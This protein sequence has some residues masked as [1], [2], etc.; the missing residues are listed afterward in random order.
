M[1]IVT[2]HIPY[3]I[4]FSTLAKALPTLI[5]LCITIGI[6]IYLV[7]KPK[8]GFKNPFSKSPKGV[9]NIDDI[10]NEQ[11][12]EREITIDQILEKI[13]KKGLHSLSK[14]EKEI[15]TNHSDKNK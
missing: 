5:I 7:A 9:L 1:N 8:K 10:Y 15:L 14:K 3:A 12:K 13:H 6:V 11:R 2:A 4:F